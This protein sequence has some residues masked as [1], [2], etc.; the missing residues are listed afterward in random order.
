MIPARQ[1]A[2]VRAEVA[3]AETG[4]CAYVCMRVHMRVFVCVCL[5]G[6]WPRDL[7]YI[8]R[9]TQASVSS[10]PGGDTKGT[11]CVGSQ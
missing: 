2:V 11:L 7:G 5:S 8:D 10:S 4:F 1:R 9:S 6:F 3:E